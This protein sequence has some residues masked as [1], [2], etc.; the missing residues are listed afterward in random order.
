[1]IPPF[2]I[3]SFIDLSAARRFILP[4]LYS[5][6]SIKTYKVIIEIIAE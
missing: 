4:A 6:T 3:F 1:M 2:R 5:Y